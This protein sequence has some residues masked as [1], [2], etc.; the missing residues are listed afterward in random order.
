MKG[1]EMQD[2]GKLRNYNAIMDA[3]RG[4][5]AREES[6]ALRR[7]LFLTVAMTLGIVLV[8]SALEALLYLD[9]AGRTVLF[10]L[11]A[12]GALV[13]AS[14]FLFPALAPRF[15]AARRKSEDSVALEVGAHFPQVKDRLLNAM[16]VFREM[17]KETHVAWSPA[18]VDAGF[19]D[20][21]DAFDRLD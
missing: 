16:Q 8:A 3:L 19:R 10:S 17:R 20:V 6:A 11:A 13:A 1:H 14:V 7:A 5:R 21:A 12:A 2:E 15:S 4:V 9:I 18:L